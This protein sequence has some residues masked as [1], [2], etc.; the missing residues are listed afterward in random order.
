[1]IKK[2]FNISIITVVLNRKEL[3]EKTIKSIISQSIN[4]YELI[5]IDGGSDDGT[6]EIIKKYQ[7]KIAYW[8]S[9]ADN[10]IYDAMNKG[11]KAATGDYIWFLNAG[12]EIY[13]NDI[14][15]KLTEFNILPDVFYGDVEYIDSEGNHLGTRKLKKPPE[16]F[17]WINLLNGMVVSHQSFIIR[18]DK[19]EFYNLN[20]KYCADI[21]WMINSMR[22]CEDI[23]NT[24]MTLSKF[25]TG[26]YSK[27]NILKSNIERYKILR[28]N[29]SFFPVLFSH[30]SI[31]LI[32][33]KYYFTNKKKL[34]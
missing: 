26:G 31:G 27:S 19:A 18:R 8:V 4:I 32:F 14:I 10:G 33:V 2:E 28:K 16:N 23:I 1:M 30:L 29:F 13:S 25:L 11:L 24:K 3:L 6:L 17:N 9:E 12:D 5:I 7:D 20:Y 22:K 34:Y 21:D 15:Q